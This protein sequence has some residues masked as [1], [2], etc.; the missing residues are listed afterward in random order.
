MDE[1]QRSLA[2]F[3]PELALVLGLV[4]VVIAD[5]F[6][7]RARNFLTRLLTVAA[8]AGALGATL[9]L[10]AAGTRATLFSGM[11]VLDPLGAALQLILIAAGL[12][13][14]LA[15]S[16]RNSRELHGLGQ[17]ELCSLACCSPPRATS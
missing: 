9:A 10:Q 12:L 5:T 11:L 13:T 16:F 4:L 15:F 14:V 6:L 2:A 17:G 8:L 1:L 3:R 7:G